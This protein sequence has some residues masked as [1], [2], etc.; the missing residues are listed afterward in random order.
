MAKGVPAAQ[1]IAGIHAAQL[2]GVKQIVLVCSTG[3]RIVSVGPMLSWRLTILG[4]AEHCPSGLS[5]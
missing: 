1:G 5:R 2:A 4:T 3:V